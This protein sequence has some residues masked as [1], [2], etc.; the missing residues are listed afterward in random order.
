M[1]VEPSAGTVY[2]QEPVT[3][4][5]QGP[6]FSTCASRKLQACASWDGSRHMVFKDDTDCELG[7]NGEWVDGSRAGKVC[8]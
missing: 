1:A 3:P 8:C 4:A 2:R 6:Q 7:L 5:A